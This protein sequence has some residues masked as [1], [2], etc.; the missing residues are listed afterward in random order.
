LGSFEELFEEMEENVKTERLRKA[1]VKDALEM[2]DDEKQISFLNNYF[3]YKKIRNVN[4]EKMVKLLL[5]KKDEKP[6]DEGTED[7][8]DMILNESK[9]IRREAIKY[10]KKITLPGKK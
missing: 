2:S 5:S 9:K 6:L 4:S 8:I 1:L 3:I 7:L 10:K